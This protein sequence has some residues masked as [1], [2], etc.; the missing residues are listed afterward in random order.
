MDDKEQMMEKYHAMIGELKKS[1][2]R[3][4]VLGIMRR[5]DVSRSIGNKRLEVNAALSS[6]CRTEEVEFAD[7]EFNG[8]S[9]YLGRDGLHLNRSG[10]D[11]LSRKIFQTL[12][13]P[14]IYKFL[15]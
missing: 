13:L 2:K 9:G 6:L 3:I 7:I 12:K 15:N 11:W 1:R 8:R 10:S 4:V 5:N 14:C